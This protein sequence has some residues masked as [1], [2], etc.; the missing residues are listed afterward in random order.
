MKRILIT[1]IAGFTGSYLAEYIVKNYPKTKV[2]G[3]YYPGSSL[4]DLAEIEKKITLIPCDIN[5]AKKVKS[6]LN[7]IVPDNI[8]HLAAQSS[9]DASFDDPALTLR[10][11]ILGQNNLLDAARLQK[12]NYQP[13]ILIT[14]SAEEYGYSQ[15]NEIPIKESAVLRPR[16]PYA[17]SKISQDF[18]GYQYWEAYKMKIIRIRVFNHT[19]PRRLPIFFVSK[20]AKRIAE[21]EKGKRP[22]ELYI[23]DLSVTR[24]F[25]DVRDVVRG[26]VM[27]ASRCKHG[28]VYNICSG[29]G[30]VI[31]KIVDKL[32][33]LSTFKNINLK[34]DPNRKRPSEGRVIIG[35][36]KKLFQACGWKPKKDFLNDTLPDML[37]WWR[38]RI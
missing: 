8:F 12:E 29:K 18:M 14:C 17:V 11:N 33:E 38:Q 6:L 20:F 32:L 1:G 4:K 36:N 5:N 27:A 7:D 21:I 16:S 26:F 30:I 31:Q 34:K 3:W 9:I 2:F 19:G 25:S 13:T 23:P 24:D 22:P 10:T 35:S 37:E 15:K 28:Q